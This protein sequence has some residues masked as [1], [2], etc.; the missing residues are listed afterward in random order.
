MEQVALAVRPREKNSKNA[1]RRSRRGGG[2]PGVI[3]GGEAPPQPIFIDGEAFAKLVQ[4]IHLGTTIFHLTLE[5][6]DSTPEKA[7]IRAIQ[8]DPVYD[9]K[10]L[11]VDFYRIRL[12]KPIVLDIPVHA[13]GGTPSGVKMGGILESLTRRISIRCLPLQVPEALEIDV[14]GL[15]IGQTLHISDLRPPEG[16]EILTPADLALFLVAAPKLEETPEAAAPAAEAAPAEGAAAAPT[17]EA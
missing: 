13:V 14:S 4:R 11:H 12:D 8:R 3:Y 10:L 7:I 16:V 6:G 15:E 17:P 9:R 5:G 2:L 1:N